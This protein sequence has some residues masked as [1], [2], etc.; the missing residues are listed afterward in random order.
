M[1]L[2]LL[3]FCL[4]PSLVIVFTIYASRELN[5]CVNPDQRCHR[6][7]WKVFRFLAAFYILKVF[8]VLMYEDRTQN[9]D[10]EIH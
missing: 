8:Q 5:E 2:R 1:D 7:G 10:P 4:T 9:Y 6:R 3:F